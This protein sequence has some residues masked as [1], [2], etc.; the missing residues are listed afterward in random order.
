MAVSCQFLCC[1]VPVS[2]ELCLAESFMCCSSAHGVL[3]RLMGACMGSGEQRANP[4]RTLLLRVGLTCCF[5]AL[6]AAAMWLR[7]RRM[8]L[9]AKIHPVPG[10][11]GPV[12]TSSTPARL[13]CYLLTRLRVGSQA[14]NKTTHPT[15]DTLQYLCSIRARERMSLAG[16]ML[17][18]RATRAS[19]ARGV[20]KRH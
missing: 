7:S 18:P 20:F 1:P 11:R 6:M 16:I 17:M 12:A 13:V 2:G 19:G 10:Q 5:T 15:H 3:F 4:S 8:A 14:G 9:C